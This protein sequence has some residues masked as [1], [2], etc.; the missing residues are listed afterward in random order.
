[1]QQRVHKPKVVLIVFFELV[2]AD[3]NHWID[4]VSIITTAESSLAALAD[5]LR[6]ALT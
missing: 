5:D 6:L 1:M 2:P 3:L 4:L